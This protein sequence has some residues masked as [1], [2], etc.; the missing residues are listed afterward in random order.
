MFK[1][2]EDIWPILAT[3]TG[4]VH[5]GPENHKKYPK[6]S[7]SLAYPCDSYRFF[8]IEGQKTIKNTQK[9]PLKIPKKNLDPIVYECA[10]VRVCVCVR[11]TIGYLPWQAVQAGYHDGMGVFVDMHKFTPSPTNRHTCACT[12]VCIYIYIYVRILYITHTLRWFIP[13]DVPL[14]RYL[15]PYLPT[16]TCLPSPPP[17]AYPTRKR[18]HPPTDRPTYLHNSIIEKYCKITCTCG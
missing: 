3:R 7:L 2:Y 18:F 1:I 12:Y 17:S 6:K 13:T 16:A 8:A 11:A 5:R 4:S 9:K 10:G 14:Y 15:P